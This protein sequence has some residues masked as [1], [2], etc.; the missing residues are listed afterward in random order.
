MNRR[1][2]AIIAVATASAVAA[3]TAAV[4]LAVP[5]QGTAT[6]LTAEAAEVPGTQAELIGTSFMLPEHYMAFTLQD[7]A[8]TSVG[9]EA[10]LPEATLQSIEEQ[11]VAAGEQSIVF[12]DSSTA[13][14]D[15]VTTALATVTP[16]N[17]LTLGT[18]NEQMQQWLA[19]LFTDSGGELASLPVP[20][21]P[22]ASLTYTETIATGEESTD[23]ITWFVTEYVFQY[24]DA[25]VS[26]QF[27]TVD[28]TGQDR[29]E[30]DTIVASMTR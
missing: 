8:L 27:L 28:D 18:S 7:G 16:T 24:A 17:A 29:A 19:S 22:N 25:A 9:A 30:F 21:V 26:V 5:G 20:E 12:V 3:S 1:R 15:G 14:G 6:E 23:E 11:L 2:T 10:E 13:R 4:A